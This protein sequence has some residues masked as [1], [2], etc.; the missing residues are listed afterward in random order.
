M[1]LEVPFLA[2][3]GFEVLSA[4]HIEKRVR[5]IIRL[6][7]CY[8]HLASCELGRFGSGPLSVLLLGSDH[9]GV[10]HHGNL[11]ILLFLF[12]FPN[13]LFEFSLL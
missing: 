6:W 4:S 12:T 11:Q 5:S 3:L 2:T 13:I 10:L 1:R 7:W 9:H 8:M